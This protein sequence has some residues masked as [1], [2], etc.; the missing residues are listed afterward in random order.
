MELSKLR[1]P[2]GYIWIYKILKIF[3]QYLGKHFRYRFVIKLLWLLRGLTIFMYRGCTRLFYYLWKYWIIIARLR[4]VQMSGGNF[5]N[6]IYNLIYQGLTAYTWDWQNPQNPA[7][8]NRILNQ[9]SWSSWF[10]RHQIGG[11]Q[12]QESQD[13]EVYFN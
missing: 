4:N 13:H 11:F 9:K 12:S 6:S 10:E 1:V 2:G 8:V 7:L 3:G 5:V